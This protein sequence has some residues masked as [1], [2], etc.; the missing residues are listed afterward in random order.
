VFCN[1][2]TA[3]GVTLEGL[4]FPLQDDTLSGSFPL[5]VSNEFTGQPARVSVGSGS[6]ILIWAD[7]G[8]FYTRLPKLWK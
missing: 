1:S 5:G 7:K 2:G 6:L 4:K 3:E 8:D